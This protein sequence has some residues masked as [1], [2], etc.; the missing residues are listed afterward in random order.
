MKSITW[1]AKV[2]NKCNMKM[3]SD[4]LTRFFDKDDFLVLRVNSSAA[5]KALEKT[6]I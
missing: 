2:K 3:S 1:K 5:F 6:T 4:F